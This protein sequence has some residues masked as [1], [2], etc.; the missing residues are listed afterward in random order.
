MTPEALWAQAAWTKGACRR[1]GAESEV[2]DTGEET[3]PRGD[4]SPLHACH[5]CY[6][7]IWQG[8]WAHVMLDVH[9]VHDGRGSRSGNS[10]GTTGLV[11]LPSPPPSLDQ[12]A[13][14]R[15]TVGLFGLLSHSI[16]PPS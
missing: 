14:G 8:L 4:R 16:R 1:C 3:G 10:A 7:T 9:D 12:T 2:A 11:L 13:E 15:G 6:F 5:V